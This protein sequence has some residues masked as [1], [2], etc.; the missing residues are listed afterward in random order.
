MKKALLIGIDYISSPNLSLNGCIND[1][2]TVRNMLIDAYDYD[3]NNII[4]LRDDTA[5]FNPTRENILEQM[6]LLVSNSGNLE[7]IWF[8]YSGHGSQLR[9]QNSELKEIIIPS[10]Y[11]EDG[12]IMDSEILDI[13]KNI[14]CRTIMI[15]DCCH[16]GSICNMP[17]SFEYKDLSS[18]TYSRTQTNTVKI[19]N[20]NIYV[21]SGCRDNQTSADS[22]NILDQSVGAF[23]NAFIE[24]LRASHHNIGVMEL[25]KNTCIYLSKNGYSQ[26]PLFSSSNENPTFVIKKPN[27]VQVIRCDD[28]KRNM[29]IMYFR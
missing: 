25:Y 21:F 14:K 18:S 6:N 5:D 19:A 9:D 7:E 23:S 27:R 4:I 13:I 26:T 15:F 28:V 11:N 24:C 16:S 22:F 29:K 12:V 3:P 8:H 20:Q 1:V 2:I 10:N 17:W